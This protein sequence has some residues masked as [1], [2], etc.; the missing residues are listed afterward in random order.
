MGACAG[1]VAVLVVLLGAPGLS[2][3]GIPA[4][5]EQGGSSAA[6]TN[7]DVIKMSAAGLAEDV[8]ITAMRQAPRRDFDLSAN[9]LIQLTPANVPDPIVRAMQAIE[10]TARD[11]TMLWLGFSDLDQHHRV[12]KPI[13]R[14]AAEPADS[15]LAES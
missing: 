7:Q 10:D 15:P 8:I 6:M 9:G 3:S 13:P 11:A 14:Q 1:L 12:R 2:A 4:A 5:F